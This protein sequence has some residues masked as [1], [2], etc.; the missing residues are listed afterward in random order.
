MKKLALTTI[1]GLVVLLPRFTHAAIAI[2]ASTTATAT[3]AVSTISANLGDSAATLVMVA[4]LT[5]DSNNRTVSSVTYNGHNMTFATSS[6]YGR[7]QWVYWDVATT[8]ATHPILVTLSGNVS[9]NILLAAAAYSGADTSGPLM[10]EASS[11]QFCNGCTSLTTSVTTITDNDWLVDFGFFNDGTVPS[12]GANTFK[13]TQSTYG[14]AFL[15]VYDSNGAKTPP[16]SYSLATQ[17]GPSTNI[18]NMVFAIKPTATAAT[19]Q[20]LI[21]STSGDW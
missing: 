18:A 20:N 3:G 4:F 2:N 6:S 10:A 9:N 1:V 13:R 14:N 11:T 12:A 19:T 16:G 5:V 21:I 15:D 8:T 7:K 17:V